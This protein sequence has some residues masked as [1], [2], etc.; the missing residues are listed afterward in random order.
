MIDGSRAALVRVRLAAVVA[1][2]VVLTATIAVVGATTPGYRPWADAV[3]RLASRDEPHASLMRIGF[4]VYGVL[5]VV[6]ARALGDL[7]PVKAR[8]LGW[9][10]AGYGFAAVVA[11]V[12]QKDP[13]GGPHTAT[14]QIHVASTLVGGAALLA[15]MAVTARCAFRRADRNTAAIVGV[16]TMLGVVIFPFT[17]GS[18]I[19]GAIEIFLL[20]AAT[21]W[22]ATLARTALN[23]D[24]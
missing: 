2:A 14:S 10:I 9:L 12:A 8:L 5:V 7:V 15:A 22:L 20:G 24:D 11:G 6:G 16:T 13:P 21:L 18:P 19:Y 4:V 23:A 3:S 1:S 17:W